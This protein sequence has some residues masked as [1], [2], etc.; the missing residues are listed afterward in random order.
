MY[1]RQS[2]CTKHTKYSPT[3][4]DIYNFLYRNFLM[5]NAAVSVKIANSTFKDVWVKVDANRRYVVE[6]E[7][8]VKQKIEV[9]GVKVGVEAGMKEKFENIVV[10]VG[11]SRIPSREFLSFDVPQGEDECYIS[12]VDS[13]GVWFG[14]AKCFRATYDSY[15]NVVLCSD[16]AMRKGFKNK[17]FRC[18]EGTQEYWGP[19]VCPGCGTKKCE[20]PESSGSDGWCAKVGQ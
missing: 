3:V 19:H 12:A 8:S 7:N 6:R 18:A 15:F 1:E 5:G 16:H 10:E 17:I 2:P 11:Y 9:K 20:S 4:I 13:D 14:S